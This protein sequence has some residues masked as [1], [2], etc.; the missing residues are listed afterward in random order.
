MIA[1][2][3]ACVECLAEH[4]DVRPKVEIPARA[5]GIAIRSLV[6]SA[7]GDRILSV[8]DNCDVILHDIKGDRLKYKLKA[9][10][11]LA[12]S[13]LSNG[14]FVVGN[15]QGKIILLDD[16]TMSKHTISYGD[17][18]V[19]S[20]F[21]RLDF[22]YSLLNS[23]EGRSLLFCCQDDKLVSCIDFEKVRCTAASPNG[24]QLVIA[25]QNALVAL[26]LSSSSSPKFKTIALEDAKRI[27]SWSQ[28]AITDSASHFAVANGSSFAVFTTDSVAK[29]IFTIKFDTVFLL[30][31]GT[32]LYAINREGNGIGYDTKSQTSFK[33]D[34]KLIFTNWIPSCTSFSPDRKW[35]AIG[36]S[37]G[38]IDLFS[39]EFMNR[40]KK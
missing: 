3:V 10:R 34:M 13:R 6:F 32:V 30:V 31:E 39:T 23:S 19:P 21:E 8:N 24:R 37:D 1:V 20:S 9:D 18:N 22:Q 15:T 33:L 17:G 12:A 27:E 11:I 25:S 36:Y 40:T 4:R 5:V 16:W 14:K 35:L 26:S 2:L 38:S 29:M 7:D 28:L